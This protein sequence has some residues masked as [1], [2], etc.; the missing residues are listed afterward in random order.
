MPSDR[1]DR[2]NKIIRGYSVMSLGEAAGHGMV[3]DETTLEQVVALGNA[4][5]RG[6]Q[7]A[8]STPEQCQRWLWAV[9]W[10]NNELPPRRQ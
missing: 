1:V 9:G 5:Q 2:E 6:R 3:V 7:D 10:Q 4:V 8:D